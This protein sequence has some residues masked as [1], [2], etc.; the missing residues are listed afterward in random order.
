MHAAGPLNGEG[1]A[2][3][4]E[5]RRFRR[6]P[7]SGLRRPLSDSGRQTLVCRSASECPTAHGLDGLPDKIGGQRVYGHVLFASSVRKTH[8][9]VV[10]PQKPELRDG[11]IC[12]VDISAN[13][14]ADDRHPRRRQPSGLPCYVRVW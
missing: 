6:E 13:H 3:S 7:G 4:G 11:P 14:C 9:R 2:G 5:E 12:M 1:M 10:T 8:F